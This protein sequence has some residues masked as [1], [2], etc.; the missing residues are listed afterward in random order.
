MDLSLCVG[1]GTDSGR[2]GEFEK[3][4]QRKKIPFEE[5]PT[6]STCLP[7]LNT[8]GIQSLMNFQGRVKEINL[9]YS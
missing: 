9:S 3:R 6:K 4:A 7:F 5:H 1:A 2:M 8:H